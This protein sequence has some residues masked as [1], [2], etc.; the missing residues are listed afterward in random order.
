MEVTRKKEEGA[1]EEEEQGERE[2]DDE[3]D[4]E[5]EAEEKCQIKRNEMKKT[6]SLTEIGQSQR[7]LNTNVYES[8]TDL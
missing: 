6:M 5:E 7:Y 4:C 1:A 3:E 8:R 2:E